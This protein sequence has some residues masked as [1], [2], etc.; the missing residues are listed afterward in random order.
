MANMVEKKYLAA[1]LIAQIFG[2]AIVVGL[3]TGLVK[4]G[5]VGKEL[6]VAWR[7]GTGDTVD[8]FVMAMV[9]PQFAIYVVSNSLKLALIPVYIK[10]KKQQGQ[11]AVQRL[12]SG[13]IVWA[14]GLLT[15]IAL[16]IA[17]TAPW[18]LPLLASGF[19]PEK[20]TVD[21]PFA[22]A[23]LSCDRLCRIDKHLGCGT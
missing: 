4:C 20:I 2:A 5:S 3:S 12:F 6:V 21:D 15:A 18:Y 13:V 23:Y 22:L 7:F 16:I 14:V 9:V 10:V 8:A 11:Q 1:Q 17:V 19:A